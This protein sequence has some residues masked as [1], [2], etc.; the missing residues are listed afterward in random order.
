MLKAYLPDKQHVIAC[1]GIVCCGGLLMLALPRFVAGLYALYPDAATRQAPENLPVEVYQKCIADLNAALNWNERPEYWQSQALWYLA[2][3]NKSP[4]KRP[5][6]IKDAHN[7]IIRGL[8]LSPVDPYGWYRLA[9]VGK[10]LKLPP[11]STI[12]ALRLSFYAGR[13][14]PDLVMP[15]LSLGYTY[16]NRFD[17]EMQRL[18]QK[19]IAI[20]WTF[21][22]DQLVKF[23][24]LHPES[25]AL[26]EQALTN[27][28]EDLTK[29]SYAFENLIK[30]TH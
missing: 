7:A 29:F 27:S 1:L 21:Q 17:T 20:A 4:E 19:Q 18:F 10:M 6:L 8:K 2:L 24:A 12:N 11:E 13:V 30:Q 28:P 25:K 9:A 16:F 23:V 26:V 15:R 3:S 14:E 5:A 22:P